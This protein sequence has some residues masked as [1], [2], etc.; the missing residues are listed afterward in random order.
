MST[1]AD[2][3]EERERNRE[4]QEDQQRI[5]QAFNDQGELS[6]GFIQEILDNDDVRVG[7][8]NDLQDAT[9]AKIQSMLSKQW[10]LA[11]LTSAQENDAR[12]KLEVIKM[13]ILGG[14]P[15]E[16]STIRGPTRAFLFDDSMENLEPLS[17]QER[18][19]VDELIETIKARITRGREGFERK[20]MNTSIARSEKPEKEESK[21]GFKSLF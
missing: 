4:F 11:N 8:H 21:G 9:V 18:L 15:N 16:D 7:D 10:V 17:T 6:L 12:F 5:A 20:Q 3:K 2:L 14:H 1:T 19:L 13:K